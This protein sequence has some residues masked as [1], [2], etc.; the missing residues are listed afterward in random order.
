M[1]KE[2]KAVGSFFYYSTKRSHGPRRSSIF[3]QLLPWVDYYVSIGTN[4]LRFLVDHVVL[5]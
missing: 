1:E 4:S 5:N 3:S 2:D